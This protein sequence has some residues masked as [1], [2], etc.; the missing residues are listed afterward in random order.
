MTQQ[1]TG[2]IHKNFFRMFALA[3]KE[4]AGNDSERMLALCEIP[5]FELMKTPERLHFLSV[6]PF[7]RAF[8]QEYGL[9]AAQG[10]LV[11]AG[12]S[13]MK[14]AIREYPEDTGLFDPE[15]RMLPKPLRLFEGLHKLKRF[16][17]EP[18]GISVNITDGD[19]AWEFEILSIKAFDQQDVDM[20]DC[21]SKFTT[22]MLQE[23]MMWSTGGKY[24]PVYES[25]RVMF[26]DEPVRFHIDK[27]YIS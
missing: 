12:R 24:Y 17:F 25:N 18:Q 13:F 7:A 10:M 19:V 3:V 16:F 27:K 8:H 23:F 4:A 20:L 26:S 15:F 6:Y 9:L 14:I 22:G 1:K 21:L 11:K 2:F 5:N